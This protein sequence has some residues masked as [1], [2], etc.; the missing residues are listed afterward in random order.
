MN[1]HQISIPILAL[2]LLNLALIGLLP[3]VFFRPG[4]LNANWWATAAP[5]AVAGG[6]LFAGIMGV[7]SPAAPA[8]AWAPLTGSLA[9]AL[10]A[11]S[12]GLIGY[13]LGTHREPLS[14]WHQ[15][16]DAPHRLVTHGAYSRVRHPFYLAFLLALLG[17]VLALPHWSTAAALAYALVRL[18]ATA[19][20]EERRLLASP[21]GAEYAAYTRR[22]GRLWP[23]LGRAAPVVATSP[24]V[25]GYVASRM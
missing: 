11:A 6:A 5:F 12:V 9:A 16:D 24:G 1:T 3:R 15:E 25:G 18:N 13:T 2:C 7:L 8:A 20:R 23:R 22:T 4:R 17:A 21:F 10:C 14:L 19:A